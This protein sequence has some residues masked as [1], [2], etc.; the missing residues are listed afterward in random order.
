MSSPIAS[1]ANVV[2]Y[3]EAQMRLVAELNRR[4]LNPE[5]EQGIERPGEQKGCYPDLWFRGKLI[6]EVDGE[7]HDYDG[8]AKRDKWLIENG[9]A[10]KVLHF[11]ND[12]V[13]RQPG[14][15]ALQIQ[16]ALDRLEGLQVP[17]IK[18]EYRKL[19][20]SIPKEEYESMKASIATDGQH[21]SII[22]NQESVILDGHNRYL[23]CR[24]LGITA[25]LQ[26]MRFDDPLL[27]KRFVIETNL[28]RRHLN[29]YQKAELGYPLLEIEAELARRRQK[30]LAGT[31]KG[32]TLAPNGAKVGTSVSIVTQAEHNPE[33]RST[34]IVAKKIG[35]S[36]RTFERSKKIIEEAPEAIKQKLR[37]GKTSI[38]KAYDSIQ[39][40]K[41]EHSD[42]TPKVFNV[43]NFGRFDD[44]Y[45]TPNFP[46]RTPGQIVENVLYYWTKDGDLVVDP[47]AGG[48][49]T[50]DVCKKMNRRC[51][52]MDIAPVRSDI[53]MNDIG[54]GF[55]EQ[56]SGAQLIYMDTPYYQKKK[57]EYSK[58]AVS[59]LSKEQF[60]TFIQ[61]LAQDCYN[62]LADGGYACL[63]C[64]DFFDYDG[65]SDFIF[66]ADLYQLFT[67]VGFKPIM[68]VQVPLST[69]QYAGHDV[70]VARD[71]KILLNIARDLYIF[72]K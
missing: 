13:L 68:H 8:D 54:A 48:G 23:A 47:M 58:Y 67:Q 55:P 11:D 18:D 71:Q 60:L 42:F 64:A 72:K 28:R 14:L 10:N 61:K 62:T 41:Q 45:G 26:T 66:V 46:G 57:A 12:K 63:L 1:E 44:Q 38:S 25:K 5:L 19:L 32:D 36:G 7:G 39:K 40:P 34:D 50:I 65:G 27:E 3:K 51:I 30:E 29:D 16:E 69:E 33:I 43:W 2:K 9:H 20:P 35:L 70:S 52:G 53:L 6:I 22:V 37:E 4:K 21:Y 49:T 15:V 17:T 31:R 56:A 24:E 59:N